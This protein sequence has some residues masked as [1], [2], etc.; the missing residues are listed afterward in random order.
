M[1]KFCKFG[2]SIKEII[3]INKG[4]INNEIDYNDYNR[5]ND[6]LNFQL[7]NWEKTQNKIN[8]ITKNNYSNG[9]RII[10]N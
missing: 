6:L 2:Y 10:I 8:K 4:N 5:L 7:E 3:I 1:E 9:W